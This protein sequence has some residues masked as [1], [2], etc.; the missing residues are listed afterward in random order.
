MGE[1]IDAIIVAA[2]AGKRLGFNA[3]KAFVELKGRPLLFYS[4]KIFAEYPLINKIIVVIPE[5]Y[6][7]EAQHLF[8][9]KNLAYV[10]G[11]KE[12]WESVRNGFNLSEAE[13]VLVHDA[14]RPFVTSFVIDR[15]L[16]K[17]NSFDCVITATPIVDTIRTFEGELAGEVIDRSKLI[18]VGTP[19][20]F[21]HSVLA[22]ALEYAQKNRDLNP[23]DEALLVQ[24]IGLQVG[25]A[26]GDSKNFKITTP[27]D[28][29][30]AKILAERY[31]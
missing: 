26:E 1:K 31:L 10:N 4:V 11:G 8:S 15:I 7:E 9:Y 27:E 2:G 6:I 25:V 30:I 5:G 14:A 24:K 22:K 28:F 12:R 17:R 3:P 21:R 13:W 20:L 16:E 29:E 18:R 23:T 19:Q